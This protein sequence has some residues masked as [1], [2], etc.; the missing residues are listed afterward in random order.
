MKVNSF[1]NDTD[2]A[3]I[4]IPVASERENSAGPSGQSHK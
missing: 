1:S 4:T 2:R 3:Q